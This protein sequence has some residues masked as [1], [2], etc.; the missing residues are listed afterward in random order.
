MVA[1]AGFPEKGMLGWG[2]H[3]IDKQGFSSWA[4]RGVC[5]VTANST[6]RRLIM[7]QSAETREMGGILDGLYQRRMEQEGG[8][9]PRA[10]RA[11]DAQLRA[12]LYSDVNGH[13]WVG[14]SLLGTYVCTYVGK[15]HAAHGAR[16][17]TQRSRAVCSID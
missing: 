11:P 4:R 10:W 6:G 14:S 9:S 8:Q 13:G 1:E 5:V 17:L 16:T 2:S 12:W 3:R 15:F 7:W